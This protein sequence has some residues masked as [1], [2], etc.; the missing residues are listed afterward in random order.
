MLSQIGDNE[1]V[2]GGVPCQRVLKY[3]DYCWLQPGMACRESEMQEEEAVYYVIEGSGTMKIAEEDERVRE[4]DAIYIPPNSTY[5]LVNDSDD[6]AI[7]LIVFG[8]DV[9]R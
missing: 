4:G 5:Q 9:S 3:A 6:I 2:G 8:A 1:L 7:E